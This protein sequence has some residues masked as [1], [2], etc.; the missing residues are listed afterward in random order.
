MTAANIGT[1]RSVR[2]SVAHSSLSLCVFLCVSKTT[3]ITQYLVDAGYAKYGRIGCTQPRRVAAMSVAAR[4]AQ[5]MCLEYGTQISTRDPAR[6]SLLV[7][8]LKESDVGH[9][10]LEGQ[11]DAD[12]RLSAVGAVTSRIKFVI[13]DK[14]KRTYAVTRNHGVTLV[15]GRNP[16]FNHLIGSVYPSWR[17]TIW[18]KTPTA[19]HPLLGEE[20]SLSVRYWPEGQNLPES[21]CTYN[22]VTSL[23]EA[24][25]R[26]DA[27]KVQLEKE[28]ARAAMGSAEKPWT[29]Y[30][31]RNER[32]FTLSVTR[33][34]D[35][36]PSKA[37][38]TELHPTLPAAGQ[39]TFPWT[40]DPITATRAVFR[41]TKEAARVS[42][43][44]Q[45]ASLHAARSLACNVLTLNC[46][47]VAA[48][49][50][51]FALF[52]LTSPSSCQR[53][54]SPRAT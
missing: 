48:A 49:F 22:E 1:K 4:V 21:R 35:K 53:C 6:R 31:R 42:Y 11:N 51:L 23:A 40:D 54:R 8:E 47:V 14:E 38:H 24:K 18:L 17:A 45:P 28:L 2:A 52:R 10:F 20:L 32:S 44:T 5:E 7:E 43:H 13:E 37:G 15:W 30:I 46:C 36:T 26:A 29:V 34:V 9:L 41:G 19:Q 50:F 3:Q 16:H 27:T 39:S 25:E 33:W 12:V